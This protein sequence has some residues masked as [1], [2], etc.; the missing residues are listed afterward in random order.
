V[1]AL[2]G[3]DKPANNG[4]PALTTPTTMGCVRDQERRP[5]QSPAS[6]LLP[7]WMEPQARWSGYVFAV[8]AVILT[9]L[10][11]GLVF[12]WRPLPNASMLYVL[13]VLATAALFGRGPALV[14]SVLSFVVFDWFYM[15]PQFEVTFRTPQEWLALVVFLA[16]ALVAGQL[17]ATLRQRAE[18]ARQREREAL[19]VFEVARLVPGSTLELQPLLGV[20][21]EQLK[22]IVD[23]DAA[24]LILRNERDET[25][26]LAYR[27]TLPQ[28]QIVGWRVKPGDALSDLLDEVDRRRE[29]VLVEDLGGRSLLAKD[30]LAAGSGV[31]AEAAHSELAVPL[32]VKGN[33]IG[34]QTLLHSTPGYR[35][36]QAELALIF[37]QQAAV[38]IEN[39]RLYG[40]V[41]VH[42]DEVVG[43]QRLGATLLQEH[44]FDRVLGAICEQLQRLTGAEGAAVALIEEASDWL[45][46]RAAVG[47][48]AGAAVGTRIPEDESF[49]GEALRTNEPVRISDLQC[50]P[51]GQNVRRMPNMRSVLT[52]PM[53]TRERA[54]GAFSMFNKLDEPG[55]TERDAELAMLF[56]QQ[57]AVAIENARLYAE[58]RTHLDEVVGLQ[59]VGTILLQEHDFDHLLA[60]IC[61]QLQRLTNAEGAGLLLP[62]ADSQSLEL[63]AAVGPPAVGMQGTKVPFEGTFSAEAIRTNRTVR[64]DD[65]VRDARR[66]GWHPPPKGL[67]TVLAV[68]MRT[69][70]GPLGSIALTNKQGP[71]GFN[72]RDA[73]LA[74][75]FAQQAAVAIENARLYDEARGKAALEERQK[76]ARELHDSV[77]QVLYGIAL[78]ASA[79]DELFEPAPERSRGLLR[80]VLRLADAGLAEL[81][82][83]IF[84][85]RPESLDREGL[86]GALEKQAAAVQARHGVNVNLQVAGEP[87]LPLATKEMLYRVAQEALHNAAKHA[88][89]RTLDLVLELEPSEVTLRVVDDGRG[90]DP[91]AEYPGHLGLQSMRERASAAGG[92]L[93][94]ESTLGEGTRLSAHIPLAAGAVTTQH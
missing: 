12:Q 78:N 39:A 41:R 13:A 37:A 15:Q 26:I 45:E 10:V 59:T 87:D 33:V 62:T 54:V 32:I 18:D 5:N 27:G 17:A 64:S 21:L 28:E 82:A 42:L 53:R 56:A 46:I 50:H 60:A 8:V 19:A 11:I 52:V 2:R 23:Y 66:W 6:Q 76:L 55:F 93:E 63:R 84:E 34:V 90:F 48:D 3:V 77:S 16:T 29:P 57:A 7:G 88:R 70:Q 81:R 92:R 91:S 31:P 30:L 9:T 73:E 35:P 58:V 94:I 86:T 24:E 80:D 67:R 40:Q 36:R 25:V 1:K 75:L 65:V 79:A 14:T 51:R 85:L 89:A 43:L 61:L 44:D 38:A 71:A 72:D 4:P 83:L 20:I 49:S 69:R 47:P 74:T 22:T 68:P